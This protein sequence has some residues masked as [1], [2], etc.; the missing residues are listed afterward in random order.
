M[1]SELKAD[2]AKFR[3]KAYDLVETEMRDLI[4]SKQ[5]KQL[6]IIVDLEDPKTILERLDE[7]KA[8]QHG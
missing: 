6:S 2:N 1:D 4:Q 7:L 8:A 5:G 3:K